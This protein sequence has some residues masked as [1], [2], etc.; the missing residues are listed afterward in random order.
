MTYESTGVVAGVDTH[1][2]SNTASVC[3]LLGRRLGIETFPT[4]ATG[5]QQLVAW[6]TGL[7]TPS[8]VGVEGTGSYGA[9]LTR[10][11]QA[12]DITVWEINRASRDRHGRGK[13]DPIDAQAAAAAV[14]AGEVAGPPRARDGICESIRVLHGVRRT[15]VKA[16]TAALNA[17]GGF[18]ITA[19]PSLRSQLEQLPAKQRVRTAASWRPGPDVTD[20]GNATKKAL[21]RLARRIMDL[22]TE[23]DEATAD[24]DA[25]TQQAA[26]QLRQQVGVGP[27]VA[28]QLLIT[29]GGNLDRL[30]TEAS[31]AALCGTNPIPASSG[32]KVRH[33]LNRGGDRQANRALH[34]IA[35]TRRR[36]HPP[37][38]AYVERRANDL[39]SNE[40]MRC[41]KRYIARELLPIL[42]HAIAQQPTPAA[43]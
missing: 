12:A 11:L 25:L 32:K 41:L 16:R 6:I 19:P 3:D 9:G 2:D 17:F 30:G 33:R 10:A 39:T 35:V 34:V 18:I 36:C 20:S 7:G 14:L 42:K 28:A 37:T 43:A 31:F 22:D 38:Q 23:I 27:E 1:A 4:T 8:A 15:A 5:N 29:A 21:R 24:L 26:P 13:S 40:I